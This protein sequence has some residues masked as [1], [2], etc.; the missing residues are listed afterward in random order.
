PVRF[1]NSDPTM[2]NVHMLPKVETNQA[3]DISQGPNGAPETRVFRTPELMIPVRCN[4]H[5]WMEA[6]INVTDNPFYAISGPDGHFEIRGLPPGTYTLVAD[7]EVLGQKAVTV[8]IAARQT[9]HQDF[10]FAAR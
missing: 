6:F 1:T 10:T 5:P 3:T 4:N 7:H 9:V 8:T 2:H